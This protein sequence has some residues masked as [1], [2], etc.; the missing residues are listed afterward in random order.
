MEK[1]TKWLSAAALALVA[2][3]ANATDSGQFRVTPYVGHSRVN[4]EGEYL[5]SGTGE[6][7]DQWIVGISAGYRAP[8]GLLVEI[9]IAASGE[10]VF[11][12]LGAGD[13]RETYVAAG[14]DFDLGND[15]HL[16]PK[17]G[18]TNWELQGGELQD[19]V[20]ESGELRDSIDGKDAYLELAVTKYFNSHVG[21]GFSLRHSE[22]E[23]G[24]VNSAAFNFVWAF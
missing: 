15:W 6:T 2:G 4:V 23:F 8:F 12:W 9:G 17:L 21:I 13:V 16:S 11:G 3:V 5:E 19:V 14:F 24:E 10:P 20:D 22:V 7:M 18:M 1:G